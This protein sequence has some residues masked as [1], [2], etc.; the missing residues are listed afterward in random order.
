[1]SDEKTYKLIG[2]DGKPYYSNIMGTLGGH[3][4]SKIYGRFDCRAALRAIAKGGYVE[5]R[6][7]F[8]DE[9]TAISAGYRPCAI[10]MPKE[11]AEWKRKNMGL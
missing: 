2:A 4:R 7:F 9:Q 6:V 8:A 5:H 11:Y 10:C 1:M 3:K